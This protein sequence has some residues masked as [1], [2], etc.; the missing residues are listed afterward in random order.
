MMTRENYN[1]TVNVQFL[2][3]NGISYLKA[4]PIEQKAIIGELLLS[5]KLNKI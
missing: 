2:N 4:V 5:P 3:K 1:I